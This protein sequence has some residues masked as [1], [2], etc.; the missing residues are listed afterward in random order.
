MSDDHGDDGGRVTAPMQ[1]FSIGQVT[2]GLIVL[3]VGLAVA[4]AVPVVV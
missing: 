4:Y 1:E 3:L 2:N